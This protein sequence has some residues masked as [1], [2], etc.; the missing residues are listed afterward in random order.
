MFLVELSFPGNQE[1]KK[2]QSLTTCRCV[3]P[4][5][6]VWVVSTVLL[7]LS[8]PSDNNLEVAS[9]VCNLHFDKCTYFFS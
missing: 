5:K 6:V 9:E 1:E 2:S 8:L 4:S 7:I 3:E